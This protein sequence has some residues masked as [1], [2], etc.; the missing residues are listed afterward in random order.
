VL[1]L[2]VQVGVTEVAPEV[3]RQAMA[4][5]IITFGSPSAVK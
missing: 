4:A 3:L 1:S 5:D 2:A